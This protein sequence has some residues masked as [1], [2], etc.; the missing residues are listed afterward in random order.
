MNDKRK[1][2]ENVEG[3]VEARRKFLT[4]YALGGGVAAAATTMPVFNIRSLCPARRR[5]R[6]RSSPD[7][8]TA[9]RR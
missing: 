8:L 2:T 1:P 5:W 6:R 9:L 4:K 3:V 7:A